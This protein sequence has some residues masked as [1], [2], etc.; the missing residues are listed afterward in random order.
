MRRSACVHVDRRQGSLMPEWPRE[1]AGV[2]VELHATRRGLL[3][4]VHDLTEVIAEVLDDVKDGVEHG[5]VSSLDVSPFGEPHR[6]NAGEHPID[7]VERTLEIGEKR[8]LGRTVSSRE[9]GRA[10]PGDRRASHTGNDPLPDVAGE[11]DQEITDAVGLVVRPPPDGIGRQRS[12]R[13]SELGAV[14][15]VQEIARSLE[16]VRSEICVHVISARECGAP[17]CR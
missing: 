11:M 7:V 15:V 14:F 3:R 9:L 17:R 8:F 4:D 13:V 6:R 10:V 16:E 2:F 5:N 1:S 12:H